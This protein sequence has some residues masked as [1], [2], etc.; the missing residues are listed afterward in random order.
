MK[1]GCFSNVLS[2]N[3]EENSPLL[4]VSVENRYVVKNVERK[5]SVLLTEDKRQEPT[6]VGWSFYRSAA[7]YSK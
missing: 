6:R 1:E 2:A 4:P 3:P 7:I 5:L